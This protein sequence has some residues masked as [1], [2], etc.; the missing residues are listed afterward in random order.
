MNYIL[1]DNE[2]WESLL[3][4]T[5]LRPMS[6]IR[7][8]IFTIQEKWDIFLGVETSPLT[9]EYLQKAYP[10][11]TTDDNICIAGNIIPN[12]TLVTAITQLQMNEALISKENQLIAARTSSIEQLSQ[13]ETLQ[14]IPFEGTYFQLT[15]KF[16]IFLHNGEEIIND[17]KRV[18]PTPISEN[19]RNN[20]LIFGDP[21]QLYI[22]P[23]AKIFGA[24]LNCTEG[25]IY[26]GKN[27]TVMEGSHLRGPL[28]ILDDAIVKMGAKIYGETTIGP[29]CKVGGEVE[30]AVMFGYSNKAH[31]GYLGNSVIGHWC[32]IGA[33][34]ITSNLK[35]DYSSIRQWNYKTR[36]FDHTRQQF[37]GLMMGDHSKCGINVAINSGTVMGICTSVYGAEFQRFYVANFMTGSPIGGY[38]K[39]NFNKIITSEKAMMA[40]RNMELKE[41]FIEIMRTLYEKND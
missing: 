25:P 2:D 31:D 21:S 37:C 15:E 10:V 41:T 30:N 22:D 6:H 38:R 9:P 27:V 1:F 17:L 14:K 40:R 8:G 32:N 24:T 28:A 13:W 26:I 39:N 7:I 35:N 33:G 23:T 11:H 4:F 16:E 12:E 5:F 34:T 3:P 19:V 20:N 29:L 18:S 36:R